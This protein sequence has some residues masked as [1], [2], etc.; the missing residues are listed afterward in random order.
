VRPP[1]YISCPYCRDHQSHV[2][3][4]RW[5]D[6]FLAFPQLL[7]GKISRRCE[8]CRRRFWV[9]RDEVARGEDKDLEPRIAPHRW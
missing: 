8:H 4:R 9:A 1:K 7:L 3:S 5:W 6:Y 2:T